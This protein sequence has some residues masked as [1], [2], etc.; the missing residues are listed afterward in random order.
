LAT[1]LEAGLES[2]DHVVQFYGD[3]AELFATAG[4]CLSTAL[5]CGDL[6]IVVAT[7]AHRD[8]LC[9]TIAAAGVNIAAARAAGQLIELD[10]E[11][12]LAA[13][14]VR[15]APDADRFEAEVGQRLRAAVAAGRTV[16][17]FGEMVSLLS[18]AGQVP[19]ALELEELWNRLAADVPFSLFCA[20]P[21][22]VTDDAEA[23][24]HICR[25]HTAVLN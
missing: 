3:D 10:A 18:D 15:G 25:C 5:E 17:A 20:Y 6:T 2:G 14:M 7:E 11:E 22:S 8:G 13:L 24:T 21:A 4:A 19:E 12:T 1:D 9:Q 16:T 23:F